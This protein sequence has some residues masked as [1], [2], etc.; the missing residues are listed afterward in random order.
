MASTDRDE[1]GQGA[2]KESWGGQRPLWDADGSPSDTET[3]S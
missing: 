2:L 1:R 3:D